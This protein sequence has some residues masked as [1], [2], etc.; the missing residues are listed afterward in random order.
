[1][2]HFRLV[3]DFAP[4]GD[5]P[6]GNRRLALVRLVGGDNRE[7]RYAMKRPPTA[8]VGLALAV[9]EERNAHSNAGRR[10]PRRSLWTCRA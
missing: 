9:D 10:E 1:M 6:Q 4:T 8:A 5:Q 7:G 2:P 3:S